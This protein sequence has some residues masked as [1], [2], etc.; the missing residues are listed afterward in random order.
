MTKADLISTVNGFITA[1][2]TF[3]KH[4]NS[5]LSLINELFQT[6]TNQLL[7]TGSN[8]FYLNLNYKKQGN[9][10]HLSGTIQNKYAIAKSGVVVLTIPNALYYATDSQVITIYGV[11]NDSGANIKLTVNP[12]NIT[13]VGTL[14]PNQIININAHYQTE[15]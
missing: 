9:L 3:V 15:D 13:L 7:A 10:T 2:I 8:V 5:M 12:T 1:T 11:A 4:R 14:A 6:T